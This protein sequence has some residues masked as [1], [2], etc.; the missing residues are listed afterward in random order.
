MHTKR[1]AAIRT[2]DEVCRLLHINKIDFIKI[3]AEGHDYEVIQGF[4]G[5]LASGRVTI[6]QF[7]HEGGRYLKDFY[8]AFASWDYALGKLYA[9]HVAFC[10][11][12]F[13]ME[14]CLGPNYVAVHRTN[15]NLIKRL[16]AGWNWSAQE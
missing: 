13:E 12:S 2:G 14:H 16:E 8:D 11:H 15:N 10:E 9:N 3:D 4:S 5:M 7:E 6:I 1:Q